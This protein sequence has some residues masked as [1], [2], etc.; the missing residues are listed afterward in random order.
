VTY[1][2]IAGAHHEEEASSRRRPADL[3]SSGRRRAVSRPVPVP[4]GLRFLPRDVPKAAS[5]N[6]APATGQIRGYGACR[7]PL[8]FLAQRRAG[9]LPYISPRRSHRYA[10]TKHPD[11]HTITVCLVARFT[12]P[13][14]SPRPVW[15]TLQ[16]GTL[17]PRT[18][19]TPCMVGMERRAYVELAQVLISVGLSSRHLRVGNC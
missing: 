7:N 3:E 6:L 1:S 16:R 9:R 4:Q 5:S 18:S 19:W 10:L 11:L 2:P 12:G 14:C 13:W 8:G 17:R 15:T